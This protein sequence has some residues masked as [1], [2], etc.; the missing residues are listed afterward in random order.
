MQQQRCPRIPQGTLGGLAWVQCLGDAVESGRLDEGVEERGYL[1]TSPAARCG[2][3]SDLLT[4]GLPSA[5]DCNRQ[6]A[7]PVRDLLLYAAGHVHVP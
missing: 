4:L 6:D 3:R 7:V 1:R 2:F 5:T